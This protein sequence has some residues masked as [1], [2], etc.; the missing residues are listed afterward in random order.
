MPNRKSFVTNSLLVILAAAAL[1]VVL[2]RGWTNSIG[3]TQRPLPGPDAQQLWQYITKDNP[4]KSWKNF[5]NLTNRYIRANEQPHGD[6]IAAYLNNQAYESLMNPS[7]PFHMKYASIIV[8]E[9]YAPT[10]GIPSV[11][12]PLTSV[13]V[14]LTSLTVM[15]KVKGYQRTNYEQEWFWVMY[16]CKNGK[17]DGSVATISDQPWLNK[18]IPGDKDTFA[19]YKGEVVVGKPWLCVECHQ[20]ARLYG[21]YAFGDYVFRLPPFAAK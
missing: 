16:G 6:W 14:V 8:K 7:A 1:L 13:P 17:C 21:E 18:M 12:P 19:F 5:P 10:N 4:Y 20:R 3:A 2:G 15:Y 11:E 9:N